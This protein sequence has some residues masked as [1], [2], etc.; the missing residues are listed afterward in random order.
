MA[1]S[2]VAQ[3]SGCHRSVVQGSEMVPEPA[4]KKVRRAAEEPVGA[5]SPAT[6]LDAA[7]QQVVS[8]FR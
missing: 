5:A 8:C 1:D 3:T 4:R 6:G 2:S 7:Q